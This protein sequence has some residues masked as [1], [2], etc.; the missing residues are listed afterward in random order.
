M[1]T[2]CPAAAP[3]Q[4]SMEGCLGSH[5]TQTQP[6][7]PLLPLAGGCASVLCY[8]AVAHTAVAAPDGVSLLEPEWPAL[9]EGAGPSLPFLG[10]SQVVGASTSLSGQSGASVARAAVGAD[11]AQVLC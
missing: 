5:G 8:G 6:P 7:K 10:P 3:G 1:R 2:Q 4:A 9:W 11:R